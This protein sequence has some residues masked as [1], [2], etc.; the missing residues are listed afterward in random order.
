MAAISV[1]N[2]WTVF[3]NAVLR[4]LSVL[5][6]PNARRTPRVPAAVPLAPAAP[7]A[8]RIFVPAPR[9]Y[10]ALPPAP[11]RK[12]SLPP[13]IKQR[14]SAE[15]HGSSPSVRRVLSLLDETTNGASPQEGDAPFALDAVVR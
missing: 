15:A 5:G 14:I 9:R 7:E 1:P 12:R 11:P 3:L 13:T 4:V 2:I 8:G 6:V 10:V